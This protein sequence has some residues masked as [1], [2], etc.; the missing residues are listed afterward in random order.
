MRD[1]A[2]AVEG[3]AAGREARMPHR[4]RRR[5]ADQGQELRT[6][7]LRSG[8]GGSAGP[9]P[10]GRSPRRL[11]SP[12]YRQR[13]LSRPQAGPDVLHDEHPAAIRAQALTTMVVD[14]V[15]ERFPATARR[16]GRGDGRM[17]RRMD[18][19]HRLSLQVHGPYL[20]DEAADR[21]VLRAQHL[22]QR[23]SRRENVQV[24]RTVRRRRQI[25]HRLGLSA[26]RGL[27]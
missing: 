20:A 14:G 8:M 11:A 6:S 21:R 9:G 22:D 26:R 7:G 12:L 15:F 5:D 2:M 3:N 17:G 19:A 13:F 16:H 18:R 23:R 10:R 24:H 1:S 4:L 27:S 25:L